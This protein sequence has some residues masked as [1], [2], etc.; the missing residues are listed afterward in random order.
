VAGISDPFGTTSEETGSGVEIGCAAHYL[1]TQAGTGGSV[2]Y[3]NLDASPV[4]D[5][6]LSFSDDARPLFESG[7]LDDVLLVISWTGQA[8]T[9]A[10]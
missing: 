6:Q 4:G 8:P 9:W 10:S 3:G 2:F 7:D 1:V 5:W